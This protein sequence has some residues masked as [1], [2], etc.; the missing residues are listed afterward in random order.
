MP[1]ELIV[2]IGM[3]LI[4]KPSVILGC[5]DDR[6]LHPS[7]VRLEQRIGQYM[8]NRRPRTQLD[9]LH[10]LL[11]VLPYSTERGSRPLSFHV[12]PRRLHLTKVHRRLNWTKI[13]LLW[14]SYHEPIR[15]KAA[16]V[17]RSWTWFH[18]K[19]SNPRSLRRQCPYPTLLVDR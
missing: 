9:T 7:I 16:S 14:Q 19:N 3:A 6:K 17:D 13:P 11:G 2:S 4:E 18:N 5:P 10:S 15:S 8:A 1:A 12:P